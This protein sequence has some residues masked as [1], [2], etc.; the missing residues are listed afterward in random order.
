MRKIKKIVIGLIVIL[1]FIPLMGFGYLYFK[2][3]SMYDNTVINKVNND[4]SGSIKV[5]GITNILLTGVDGNS[6]DK[7]NRSDAMM[8]LTIDK[9]NNDIRI[10]S[11]A[12]DTYVDIPGHNTEKLTHAYSYGGPS[13]LLET[14]NKNFDL[15]I[16]KYVAVSFESFKHVID[17]IGGVEIEVLEKEVN[18]IP[19]VN[20]AGKQILNGSEA[21]AYSQIRYADN[22]YQ[23]DSRQRTVIQSAFN[24]L[25][26]TSTKNI[27]NVGI[28][29]LSY[30]K[31]NISPLEAMDLANTLIKIN[32]REFD[33]MEFP[34]EGHR[35]G[36]II[37]DKTG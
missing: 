3:N 36:H 12:R 16:D 25:I 8:I 5:Q 11:L 14:I 7:G 24:K 23:R 10:T 28:E 37:N 22:A 2:L 29:L 17:A 9:N 4:S 34:L 30:T 20:S 33:Q 32:D 18:Y 27:L 26:G 1:I 31:T 13:L 35:T 19:G 6:L 15:N 21:L